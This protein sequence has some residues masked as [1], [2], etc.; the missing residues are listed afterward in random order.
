MDIFH[1]KTPEELAKEW[2]KGLKSE[3]RNMD[4]SIRK[5]EMEEVKVKNNIKMMVKKGQEDNAKIVARELIKTRKAKERL[6]K[7][8]AQMNSVILQLDQQVQQLRVM[9]ALQKSAD[10]MTCMNQL[11]KL[12]D[13]QATIRNMSKE[14]EKA[15]LIEEMVDD[16]MD[17]VFED[18]D[19]EEAADEEVSQVLN[20]VLENVKS[21]KVGSSKLPQKQVEEE[22]EEDESELELQKR[23]SSLRN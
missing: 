14:M 1:K 11:M 4:R 16:M 21:T 6:I 5:I 7:T 19:V 15:G 23:L 12:P 17:D 8:K 18:E 22:E 10:V 3:V 2:K 20:E 13:L 9:G